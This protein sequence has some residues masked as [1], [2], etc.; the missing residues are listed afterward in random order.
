[1][2]RRNREEEKKN[3]A[4]R[5]FRTIYERVS[6]V[7]TLF[8]VFFVFGLVYFTSTKNICY[9]PV[10][11]RTRRRA[12]KMC[13]SFFFL[14]CPNRNHLRRKF[15]ISKKKRD[16]HKEKRNFIFIVLYAFRVWHAVN[17]CATLNTFTRARVCWSTSVVRN[18]LVSENFRYAKK[19]NFCATDKTHTK[20]S[21]NVWCQSILRTEH[22]LE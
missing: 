14:F 15:E 4:N 19:E 11:T 3:T 16:I 22:C 8:F 18:E 2:C 10:L 12:T 13:V 5:T 1:M 21:L 6:R 17:A 7:K 9:G 20:W